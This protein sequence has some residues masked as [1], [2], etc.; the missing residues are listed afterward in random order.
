MNTSTAHI[1]PQSSPA[2]SSSR[3]PRLRAA[4]AIAAM[5]LAGSLLAVAP[6]HATTDDDGW[7][8]IAHLSP[9]TKAVDVRVS[10]LSGNQTFYE[11]DDVAYGGVSPYTGLPEG[12]YL[13]TMVPSESGSGVPVVS[14]SVRVAGGTATTMAAYGTNQDLEV[15]LFEDDLTI[16]SEGQARIRLIQ[17][18]TVADEVDVST[19]TGQAIA[20]GAGAGA[21][22]NYAEVGAGTWTLLLDGGDVSDETDVTLTAGSVSTLFVLDTAAGGLTIMPVLD[23]SA[24]GGEI[25]VGGVETGFAAPSGLSFD[26]SSG[27][28]VLAE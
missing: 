8:R 9:D 7:I 23:S 24:V 6:A 11:L 21:A 17:A 26:L 22:T 18:S 27:P 20:R 5:A 19:S 14:E 4:V 25:P 3:R 2:Q 10:S 13:V 16:P 15:R 12:I 1:A 28:A